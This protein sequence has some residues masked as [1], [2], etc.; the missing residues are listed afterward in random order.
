[1]ARAP[2]GGGS[3]DADE[4]FRGQGQTALY[5]ASMVKAALLGA[6]IGVSVGQWASEFASLLLRKT[7]AAGDD[8]VP[9]V[10]RGVQAARL[11]KQQVFAEVVVMIRPRCETPCVLQKRDT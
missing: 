4:A 11:P 6:V 9:G 8:G 7:H 1:M 10:R 3:A 2:G 5:A